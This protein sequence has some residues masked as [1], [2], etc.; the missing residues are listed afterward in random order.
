M[1][2]ILVHTRVLET[3]SVYTTENAC[4]MTTH[5]GTTIDMYR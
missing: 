3:I 5:A 4:H 2:T 1:K